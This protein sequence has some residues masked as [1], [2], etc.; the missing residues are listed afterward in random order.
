MAVLGKDAPN[1]WPAVI[2][3]LTAE[4]QGEQEH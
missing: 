3:R 4:W 2:S 1:L